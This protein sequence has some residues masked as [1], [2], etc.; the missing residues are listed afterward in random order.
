MPDL[1]SPSEKRFYGLMAR[2]A[3]GKE[4]ASEVEE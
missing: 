1:C 3:S 2:K 4:G